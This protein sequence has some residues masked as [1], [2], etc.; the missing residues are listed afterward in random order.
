MR[1]QTSKGGETRQLWTTKYGE[2]RIVPKYQNGCRMA[3][4]WPQEFREKLVDER[5]REHGDSHASSS[6]EPSGEPKRRLV[7]GNQ[8][9]FTH[10]PKDRN[11]E[12][13]QRP[14]FTWPL[15]RRRTGEV[16]PR[17]EKF[18]DLTTAD[19]KILGEGRESRNNHRYAVVVQDLG[20]QW[21]RS[22]PFKRKTSQ[23]TEW[24]L[25]KFLEPLWKPKSHIH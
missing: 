2:H 15:T 12:I 3:A 6:H 9:D 21:I 17:A 19:H 8:S 18:G 4:E 23:E 22:F 13:C 14:N 20:T 5:V 1:I 25:Q 16:V 11:C 24:S 7:P 10:F